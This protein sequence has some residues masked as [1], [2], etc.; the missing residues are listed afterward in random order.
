M[1][2]QGNIFRWFSLLIFL[3]CSYLLLSAQTDNYRIVHFKKDD[4]LQSEL[5]KSIAQ[6]TIGFIWIATDDGL[7]RFDGYSF[8]QYR[9]ELPNTYMKN[10]FRNSDGKLLATSDIGLI[11]IISRPGKPEFHT[12]LQ[13][14]SSGATDTVGAYLK[15]MYEDKAGNLWFS[16]NSIIFQYAKGEI[17][18][19]VL[20]DKNQTD[21]YQRSYSFFEDD[22]GNFYAI[23]EPGHL[24]H[25]DKAAGSFQEIENKLEIS[26]VQ[27][28]ISLNGGNALIGSRHGLYKMVFNEAG[29]LLSAGLLVDAAD[30]SYLFKKNANEIFVATWSKGLKLLKTDHE[31]FEYNTVNKI[32]QKG[33]NYIFRDKNRNY[34]LA[35]DNGILLM[36][37]TEFTPKFQNY[38]DNYIQHIVQL[39][40]STLLFT[41]GNKVYKITDGK[42]G[43]KI[44]E[45]LSLTG[46]IVLR[47]ATD[48]NGIW[49]ADNTGEIFFADD[50]GIKKTIDLSHLGGAVFM[51]TKDT[52]GNLW[53][54]QDGH[55][56][57]VKIEPDGDIRQYGEKNGVIS[58]IV[59]IRSNQKGELVFGGLNDKGFL[60]RFDYQTD[61]FI[62]LSTPIPFAHNTDININDL[63]FDDDG[64]LWLASSFGIL[65]YHGDSIS[66]LNLGNMT[67]NAVK[68]IQ[69]DHNNLL[70]FANSQG[71]IKYVKNVPVVFDEFNGM[72]SKVISYR[73]ITVD[74]RNRVWV[75]TVA[76][77]GFSENKKRY[78]VT[79]SPFFVFA[80]SAGKAFKPVLAN[81][82]FSSDSY[83]RFEY[84]SPSF[85]GKY[86][87]YQVRI[88]GADEQW[89]QPVERQKLL[90]SNLPPGD[91]V[92]Q[93]RAKQRGNYIWS[94]PLQYAFHIY[95]PW[96][97]TWWAWIA[98]ALLLGLLVW[99]IIKA[100][101]RKLQN[102]RKRLEKIVSIRTKEIEEQKNEI[103]TQRD[104]ATE[105][106]DQ[107]A[108]QNK[109]ITSSIQYASRIQKAL[110]PPENILNDTLPD[111]FIFYKP[112]D[113][114][115]GDFYWMQKKENLNF[116]VAADSTGH[117]VPGALMSML[118]ISML[119]EIVNKNFEL[120]DVAEL[121]ANEILNQLREK[122]K[123]A[124]RQTGKGGE[125]N[126][127][128]DLALCIIDCK[129]KMM[130][131]AGAYNSLYLFRKKAIEKDDFI[132]VNRKSIEK[133]G[134]LNLIQIHA[135]RMPIGIYFGE[136]K[137][138]TNNTFQLKQGDKFYIFSDG[139]I[140]QTGEKTG[141]KFMAKKFRRLLAD[142]YDKPM[143]KQKSELEKVFN[144]WRGKRVQVDDI[145]VV[146]I[147]VQDLTFS[148]PSAMNWNN[149]RILVAEDIDFNYLVIEF[150]LT[151]TG[152]KVFHARNGIEAVE[153][154]KNPPES[155]P[156][157][158]ILMDIQMPK[159]DGGKAIN[160]IRKVDKKVPIITQTAYYDS[161]ERI[162]AMESGA[163]D[164]ITK[165]V[166]ESEL[167]TAISKF[168]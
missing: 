32:K 69:I 16:N 156:F 106:H 130:Q 67:S 133:Y 2:Y 153:M 46:K 56:E 104:K 129:T 100:Y 50:N 63:A 149:K 35:T 72:P 154:F 90:I 143:D 141:R 102:D 120:R 62:N 131:F 15:L 165:P 124:L 29:N 140:D 6:D 127:G 87:T 60:Y 7:I 75:G 77:L 65:Q 54:C 74:N 99:F 48:E 157:D 151:P 4:G 83:L 105:Q 158:I 138:F 117:G 108:I 134:T 113:I 98:F 79:A 20:S 135:D 5:V 58:R 66:R 52:Y 150:I 76:G 93:I 34:W 85:P 78:R 40:D 17:Q 36:Q 70:W 125:T 122:L 55:N 59:S 68:A 101:T 3:V 45:F 8:Q 37:D 14:T 166:N 23:S 161:N 51:L 13:G 28:A 96:Y 148:D 139:F 91:Y 147:H 64:N 81:Q 1:L 80:E 160:E 30:V 112:R 128:I 44:D 109:K 163:N 38:T 159:M 24:Y 136:E 114:V 167:L 168:I 33:I 71:I 53:A 123:D 25:Y 11:E 39:T 94:K 92:L 42:D 116:L 31:G 95:L 73:C 126:D 107:I 132:D 162:N 137:L 49:M 10:V 22:F 9:E 21:D 43:Q 119:N 41:D 121:K 152:A 61:K 111:Y 118:G 89:K 88:I 19:F 164:F 86:I 26:A 97:K 115:S 144:T 12:L 146:G 57:V 103:K 145:L 84:V 142:L 82:S 155:K 47:M 27:H 110:L 18:R